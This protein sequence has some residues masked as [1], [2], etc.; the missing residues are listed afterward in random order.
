MEDRTDQLTLMIKAIDN[1]LCP[2]CRHALALEF[3]RLGIK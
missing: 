1:V 3:R 2:E